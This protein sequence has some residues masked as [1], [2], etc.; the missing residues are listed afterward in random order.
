MTLCCW[1]YPV[2]LPSMARSTYDVSEGMTVG[3]ALHAC[4]NLIVTLYTRSWVG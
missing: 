2:V 1:A 4:L 3:A